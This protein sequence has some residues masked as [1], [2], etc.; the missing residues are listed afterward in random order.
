[1]SIRIIPA[2]GLEKIFL[3]Q[4]P[5]GTYA[6]GSLLKNEGYSFQFAFTGASDG[7]IAWGTWADAEIRIDSDI[8]GCLDLY[9]VGNVGVTLATYPHYDQGYLRTAPGMYPDPLMPIKDGKVKILAGKWQ[10]VW[11][12]T[13]GELPAGE[14]IVRLTMTAPKFNASA[15]SEV[16]LRVI[17]VS[18]PEQQLKY[19]CWFHCDCVADLHGCEAFS[20]RH[21]EL[22]DQYMRWAG[23]NGV[24]MLLVPA[25]T[26]A[27][28]TPIGSERMTI[29]LVG[30]KKQGNSYEF[31]FTLL[32]RYLNMALSH[33]VC[34]FEHT[35]FFTQWGAEHAPKVM[36]EENGELK[37]IFGW[38]T[39]AD[40]PEYTA[41]LHQYLDALLPH[42]KAM[43]LHDRFYYHISDEPS[44]KQLDSYRRAKAVVQDR[45]KGYHMFDALSHVAFYEQGV[46]E[47]PVA[48][49]HTIEDFIGKVDDL[50][51]YYT[52]AQSLL[53]SNRLTSM[54]SRRNRVTGMQLYKY[55]IKGFL[56]WAFNFYYNTLSREAVNPFLSPDALGEF[57]A[58]TAYQVYP[59]ASGPIPALRLF[60][61]QDGLQDMRAM[62]LL[63]SAIGYDAVMAL[64]EKHAGPVS[65][66]SCPATDEQF[67]YV[68]EAI[69]RAIEEHFA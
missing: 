40:G 38:E 16:R 62:Q 3:D 59:H 64:I 22:I 39:Q 44:E 43:N 29:Q 11:V 10:S 32:D 67:L 33:G 50:W 34:W 14:H 31:D 6:G 24:N 2:S 8:A 57:P 51:A 18:L 46:V 48:A 60:V 49:T 28:D 55:H 37:R 25:F 4:A 61:F 9:L 23:E 30:V 5:S 27:L 69:N 68:R 20:E 45:L 26:P 42:L 21:W 47:T 65:F 15:S 56:Q 17:P 58:G 35:H 41:F 36:A 54:S 7:E 1:M 63:E 13:K 66:T 12:R 52:G 53:Y 19:T